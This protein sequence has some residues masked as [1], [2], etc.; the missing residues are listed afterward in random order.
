MQPILLSL[1]KFNIYS[2]GFM[3]ALAILIGTLL[4]VKKSNQ[5]GIDGNTIIDFVIWIVSG[6]V[7]GARLFYVL[8]Y[9]P[10][11]Y[12]A[13]PLKIIALWEGGLVF[14]GGLLGGAIAAT[15]FIKSRKLDFW[16]IGDLVAPYLSLGY[17]FVRIGC[18]LN[19]CCYGKETTLPWGVEFP[20]LIG[21][22]HPTQIYSSISGFLIF[23]ILVIL[24]Q[25]KRFHGQVILIYGILYGITRFIIEGLRENLEVFAGI[26]VSQLI[27]VILIAVSLSFYIFRRKK[28]IH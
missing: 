24:Y 4:L 1:G 27:S 21:Y 6:G 7:I 15:Y 13:N 2:W 3:L 10:K 5:E 28:A 19:G 9:S 16:V 20:Q 23:I 11:Y 8:V 18:F 12:L 25:R 17:G 26:T 14:Y 22:R